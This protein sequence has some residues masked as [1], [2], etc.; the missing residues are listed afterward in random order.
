[1]VM[2]FREFML[3]SPPELAHCGEGEQKGNLRAKGGGEE[4][5]E[6]NRIFYD[7]GREG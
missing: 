5:V 7:G 2:D 6:K 4:V 3:T 1:M